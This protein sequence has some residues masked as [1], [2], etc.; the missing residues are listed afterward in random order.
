VR[1]KAAGYRLQA[2]GIGIQES[3]RKEPTAYS[4]QP[5]AYSEEADKKEPQAARQGQQE[6]QG[7]RAMIWGIDSVFG[8]VIIKSIHS[9]A[10]I[11]SAPQRLR[12]VPASSPSVVPI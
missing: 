1:P 10:G 11:F 5:T 12:M 8:C 4:R 9:A 6:R 2:S 3:G 7:N